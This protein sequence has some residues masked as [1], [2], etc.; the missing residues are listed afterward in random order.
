MAVRIALW[1]AV[2]LEAAFYFGFQAIR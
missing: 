1:F 2:L